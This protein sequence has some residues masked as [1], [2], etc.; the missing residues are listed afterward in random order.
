MM[1]RSLLNEKMAAF[2]RRCR[3]LALPL[4]YQRLAIYKALLKIPAHPSPDEIFKVVRKAYPSI[5]L[6]TIYKTLERLERLGIVGK[7]NVLHETVRFDPRVDRHHHLVCVE[8]KRV[9]DLDEEA[10]RV[11]LPHDADGFGIP[12]WARREYEIADYQIT[13]KGLCRACRRKRGAALAAATAAAG[14]D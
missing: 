5:S 11:T 13:F 9:D 7:A 2:R 1:N 4:T 3:E 14:E 8:C 10:L 12:D 6:A